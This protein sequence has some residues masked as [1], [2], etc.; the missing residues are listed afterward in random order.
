MAY[1]LGTERSGPF[2]TGFLTSPR[3]WVWGVRNKSRSAV[4]HTGE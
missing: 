3:L 2:G 1:R 4:T